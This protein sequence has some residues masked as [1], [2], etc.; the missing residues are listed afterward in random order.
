MSMRTRLDGILR[1]E[2]GI[3]LL[4]VVLGMVFVA[5]GAQKLFQFGF[6]GLTG[7]F[8]SMGIPLPALSAALVIA[9]ELVGGAALLVGALS[10]IVAVPL[11]V[12]M[13]VAT[14]VVHLP[15][16]FFAPDGVEFTLTLM[17]GTLAILF[18][19]PGAWAVDNVLFARREDHGADREISAPRRERARAA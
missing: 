9:T 8:G 15:A 19:G 13:L 11:A 3:A 1:P 7:A 17:A 14:L 10:R 12:T 18:A 5:H 2:I 6:E 4:R 16:G